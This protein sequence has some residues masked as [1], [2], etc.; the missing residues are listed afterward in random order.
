MVVLVKGQLFRQCGFGVFRRGAACAKRY[1]ARKGMYEANAS[2]QLL[3]RPA[4]AMHK[5][6][7]VKRLMGDKKEGDGLGVIGSKIAIREA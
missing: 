1:R 2:L 6:A 3:A 7:M 5:I 4:E